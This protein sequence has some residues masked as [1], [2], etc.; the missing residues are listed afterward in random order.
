MSSHPRFK[1]QIGIPVCFAAVRVTVQHAETGVIPIS[2]VV[3]NR[4]RTGPQI[5]RNTLK[6]LKDVAEYLDVSMGEFVE[7]LE[8]HT[9]ESKAPFGFLTIA[10]IDQP[11]TLEGLTLTSAQAHALSESQ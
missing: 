5:E 7:G 10:K 9:P 3:I 1:L 11:K 8:L 6:G 2:M 4:T